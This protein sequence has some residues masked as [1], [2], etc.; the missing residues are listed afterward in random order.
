M[1]NVWIVNHYA[2]H[3]IKTGKAALHLQLAAAVRK[4]EW[5]VQIV[6]AS[7]SHPAG[8]QFLT[9]GASTQIMEWNGTET[10]FVHARKYREDGSGRWLNMIEFGTR[11]FSRRTLLKLNR[12]EVI[13]GRI[14]NPL[15]A[16]AARMWARRFKVP[17]VLEISD[18]WPDSF[19]QLG[20]WKENGVK[21]R[22]LRGVEMNL[23]RAS[24]AVMSPLPGVGAYLLENGFASLP[25]YWVP[26]GV[27]ASTPFYPAQSTARSSTEGFR[28]MY[29]GA[30][31]NAN[32][33][34]TIIL[35][36]DRYV[37]EHNDTTAQ[38]EIVGN[39][40]HAG[41]LQDLAAELPSGNQIRFTGR[42]P[43][44]QMPERLREADAL[45][46]NMR[47]LPLYKYGIALNKLYDY[48]LAARPVIF[49]SDALNNVVQEAGA[50][51]TIRADDEISL[52]KA[53]SDM[54][55]TDADT[56]TSWG[57]SGRRFVLGNYTY[58]HSAKRFLDMLMDLTGR[59]AG[60]SKSS[61]VKMNDSNGR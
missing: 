43:N 13:I 24:T 15:A 10:L 6:S 39:G 26:N 40:S 8:A 7:T 50:G 41:A 11:L 60:Y 47:A 38:L 17:F 27:D 22:I 58:A 33:V 4:S 32:A 55:D 2:P 20:A 21:T 37:R 61:R 12:P 51:I 16:M 57:E 46:A 34:D 31:G 18:I 48:M 25:F 54:V 35:A 28:F 30:L 45:V 59:S 3:P 49:A 9:N 36:F 19:V 56:R 1:R 52:A 44:E 14:T 53:M 42:L 5:N 23:L 29:T